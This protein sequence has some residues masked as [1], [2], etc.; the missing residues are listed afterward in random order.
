MFT[1]AL[2]PHPDY[3][4]VLGLNALRSRA[5]VKDG[6]ATRGPALVRG[7]LLCGFLCGDFVR[8]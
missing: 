3:D 1:P 5:A 7:G 6:R 8:G 2:H 4:R